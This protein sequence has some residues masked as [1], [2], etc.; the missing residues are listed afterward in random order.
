MM[1]T[2]CPHMDSRMMRFSSASSAGMYRRRWDDPVR[3]EVE[4]FSNTGRNASILLMATP[5]CMNI[6]KISK[7]KAI[8]SSLTS[9]PPAAEFF[10]R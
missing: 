5:C 6:F 4:C 9:S 10:S 1:E 3:V 7:R 8:L 2:Y